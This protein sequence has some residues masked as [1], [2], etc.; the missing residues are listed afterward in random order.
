M[1][2]KQALKSLKDADVGISDLSS[3][4]TV[5]SAAPEKRID[6][7]EQSTQEEY[8]IDDL[9]F[10]ENGEG[11]TLVSRGNN[12]QTNIVLTR[13]LGK[14]I[15][16]I[17]SSVFMDDSSLLSITIPSSV[18]YIGYGAFKGSA[19]TE[20]TFEDSGQRI[21]FC[22]KPASWNT[23]F[24]SYN[25]TENGVTKNNVWP[26]DV[27]TCWDAAENIFYAAIPLTA[28][29]LIFNDGRGY[30]DTNL[31]RSAAVTS[32]IKNNICFTLHNKN[33]SDGETYY[34]SADYYAPK[35]FNL[36]ESLVIGESAFENCSALEKVTIP[37]RAVSIEKKAFKNCANCETL[38]FSDNSRLINIGEAAFQSCT[39]LTSINLPEGLA[40][41]DKNAFY[42]CTGLTSVVVPSTLEVLST[43][44]FSSCPKLTNV[45][46]RTNTSVTTNQK[47]TEIKSY[48]FYACSMLREIHIPASTKIIRPCAFDECPKLRRV[49]L[50]NRFGWFVSKSDDPDTTDARYIGYS[51]IYEDMDEGIAEQY[52]CNFTLSSLNGYPTHADTNAYHIYRDGEFSHHAAELNGNNELQIGGF[53]EYNWYRRTKMPP[54]V[55]SLAG[56]ILTMTDPL[57]VAEEFWIYVNGVKKCMVLP[58]S[59]A[60]EE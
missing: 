48:A 10:I 41:V 29:N 11:Y 30:E 35:D 57:G 18:K 59:T 31:Q 53:L 43:H 16:E 33:N 46:F 45:E 13:H 1:A 19:L 15:T 32:C 25:Y 50:D 17:A 54:P 56:S 23:L 8:N 38:T 49:Y 22:K 4:I 40:T 47:Y 9:Q 37:A 27:M 6:E 51:S 24:L 5:T 2:E 26:G 21:I 7:S 34:A 42:M 39:K 55:I 12:T 28:T 44:I 20:V 52:A 58:G 3:Y 36:N 60:S 14:P